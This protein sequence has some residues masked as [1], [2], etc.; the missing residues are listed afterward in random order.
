MIG[1]MI[2]PRSEDIWTAAMAGPPLVVLTDDVGDRRLL[3]RVEDAAPR[4]A[5]AD[6][7]MSRG[8][9]AHHPGIIVA[10][11]PT[12]RPPM[13]KGRRPMRSDSPGEGEA[14]GVAGPRRRARAAPATQGSSRITAVAK[15]G[16]MA[17][18]TPKLAQPLATADPIE[19]R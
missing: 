8:K 19:A 10:R 1:P 3:R 12:S 14:H 13:M 5:T 7:R 4:P 16:K 9:G 11:P 15:S 17:L 2:D 18:R 6:T